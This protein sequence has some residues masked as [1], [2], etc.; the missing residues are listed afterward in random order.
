MRIL[1]VGVYSGGSL[2][3]WKEYF[4]DKARVYGV[5][6]EPMCRRFEDDQTRILIGD[7]ADKGFWQEVLREVPRLDVVIDDGGHQIDQQI[8]T[9][10]SLLPHLQ[11]GGVYICEDVAGE[12][13]PFHSYMDGLSRE[14]HEQIPL[15]GGPSSV[16]GFRLAHLRANAMQRLVDSIHTYPFMTV[17]EV[18]ADRREVFSS[19]RC[20][21]EWM[22]P[23]KS[24]P[25]SAPAPAAPADD[26][27]EAR[28]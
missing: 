4:G 22:P 16:A 23:T 28:R 11:P 17:I 24:A 2:Q 18:R 14:L 15:G 13:N 12:F 8:A 20:G 21:T 7:Q 26:R 10:E 25:W 9:L 1:E 27:G 3:M 5:D 6:I 19:P